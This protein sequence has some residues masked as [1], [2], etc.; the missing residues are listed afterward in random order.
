MDQSFIGIEHYLDRTDLM[1]QC[2][3]YLIQDVNYVAES[4][5]FHFNIDWTDVYTVNTT[6]VYMPFYQ[7]VEEYER[8]IEFKYS[9]DPAYLT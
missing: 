3:D 8:Y 2:I 7:Y 6:V 5:I 4:H 1:Q 9:K